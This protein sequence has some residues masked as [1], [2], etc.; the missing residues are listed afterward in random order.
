M[1]Q[2]WM[3]L[4]LLPL[5]LLPLLVQA[6]AASSKLAFDFV[7]PSPSSHPTASKCGGSGSPGPCVGLVG[8]HSHP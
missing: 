7:D 3:L 6:A 2:L 4:P 1:A 8:I 5:L